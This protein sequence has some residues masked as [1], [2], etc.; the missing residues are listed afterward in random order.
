M[1]KNEA[2]VDGIELI[3]I[4]MLWFVI[5]GFVLGFTTST[6]WEWLYYRR[7]RLQRLC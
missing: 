3:Q 4:Q 5:A 1:Q 2:D 6:L 7:K